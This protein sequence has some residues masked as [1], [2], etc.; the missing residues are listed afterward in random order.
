MLDFT[1]RT[2]RAAVTIL[3]ADRIHDFQPLKH[4]LERACRFIAGEAGCGNGPLFGVGYPGG[5]QRIEFEEVLPASFA[6]PARLI[7]ALK[8]IVETHSPGAVV[9]FGGD[10]AVPTIAVSK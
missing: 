10:L 1:P 4:E 8:R 2:F 5:K 9:G 6:E 7:G 3:P